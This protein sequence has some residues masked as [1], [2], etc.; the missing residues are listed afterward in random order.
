MRIE[1]VTCSR[2]MNAVIPARTRALD[3]TAGTTGVE[4]GQWLVGASAVGHSMDAANRPKRHVIPG[5]HDEGER[6]SLFDMKESA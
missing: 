6:T 5:S 4:H 2:R 1:P 3:L